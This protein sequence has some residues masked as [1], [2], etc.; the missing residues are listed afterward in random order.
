M[1]LTL[2]GKVAFVTGGAVGIGAS[3]AIALATAGADVGFTYLHHAANETET[4]IQAAGAKGRGW[5]LDVTDPRA[6]QEVVDDVSLAF[7]GVDIIVNNAG[8]MLARKKTQE[9]DDE[10]WRDTLALNLSSAFYC[11]RSGLAHLRRP[12]RVIFVASLAAQNGGSD[13]QLAYATA[14]AGLFG[15]TRSMAKELA[16]EGITVNA[17]APGLIL[18]TPFHETFTPPKAQA[19]AITRIPLGRAGVPSDVAAAALFL[20]SDI[21]S[22]I[23]GETLDVNGGQWF[24]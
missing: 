9:I 1:D 16:P 14:K 18:E 7:G 20:A 2:E 22:F 5:R 21:A 6:V 12:G 19:D 3:I 24:S 11:T 4:A 15:M 10:H 8:G 17:L 13:G 23:T